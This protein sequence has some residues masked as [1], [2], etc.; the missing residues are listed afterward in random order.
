MSRVARQFILPEGEGIF[1]ITDRGNN[2]MK[3]FLDDADCDFFIALVNKAKSK[4]GIE[5]LNWALI[6]THYHLLLRMFDSALLSRVMHFINDKYAKHFN[7]RYGRCGHCWQDRF[8]AQPVDSDE[9]LLAC[10]VYDD[11]NAV[12]A[13]LV[14]MPEDWVWS[15]AGFHL[16]GRPDPL[17]TP[18]ANPIIMSLGKTDEE[19]RREYR[20]ITVEEMLRPVINE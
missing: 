5:I 2:K 8:D 9:Y 10:S 16:I 14:E 6:I 13:K 3:V 19:R 1:H 20:I 11:I 7:R 4:F 15:S 12:R 17:T 18:G